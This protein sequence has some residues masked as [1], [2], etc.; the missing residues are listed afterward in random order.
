MELH[1]Q[2]PDEAKTAF[3]MEMSMARSQRMVRIAGDAPYW[4]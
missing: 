1:M 4:V 3:A 2:A